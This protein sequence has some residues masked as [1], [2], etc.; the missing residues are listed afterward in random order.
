MTGLSECHRLLRVS[1]ARVVTF[2]ARQINATIRRG[3]CQ[4]KVPH[5]PG[6]ALHNVA[7]DFQR[8]LDGS[9]RSAALVAH[10]EGC[11]YSIL[12]HGAR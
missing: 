6:G 1:R 2:E 9:G 4:R 7:R 10:L 3:V 12:S 5:Q 11:E 8:I